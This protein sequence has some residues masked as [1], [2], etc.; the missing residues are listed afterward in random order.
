[1]PPRMTTRSASRGG[2]TP[3]G[4][5]TDAHRGNG[6]RE[7]GQ[8]NTN[9]ENNE[10][11]REHGNPRDGGNNNNGNEC[12]YKEFLACQPK[13]FD[14]KGGAIA[15]TRWVEKIESARGRTTAVSMAWDDFKTL[16]KDEY[17]PHDEMHR[18]ENEFWNHTM[19]R[20]GHTAYTDRLHKLAKLVPHLVTPEFKMIDK[21]IYGLVSEIRRMVRATEPSTIQCAILKAGGLTND[22]VR[23]GLLKRSSEKRKKSGETGK[24]ED[25]RS[26][27]KRAR[28]RKGFVVIDSGKKEYKGLHPKC[29]KC[30]YHHQET[31]PCRTCFN[32]N[33][34]GHVAKDCRAV[35]KR[36][37]TRRNTLPH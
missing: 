22:A 23:N 14:D 36:V 18:L 32:C 37:D 2:A 21:Y 1:M 19:V 35:A 17:C 33:Q 8:N 4:G 30:S 27:N 25:A 11:G 5:R 13:E 31:T 15:Y 16:L 10:E 20:A 28:I 34:P 3:R 26:N 9:G 24:Q 29:A 7:S 12:S 6:N